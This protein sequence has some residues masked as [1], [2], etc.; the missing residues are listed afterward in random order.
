MS[1]IKDGGPVQAIALLKRARYV[2]HEDLPDDVREEMETRA[3]YGNSAAWQDA[4][5]AEQTKLID[6]AIELLEGMLRARGQS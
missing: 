4:R 2:R 1:E 3:A 5:N 6:E